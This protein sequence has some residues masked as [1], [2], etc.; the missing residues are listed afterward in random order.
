M[1]RYAGGAWSSLRISHIDSNPKPGQVEITGTKGTYVFD[2]HTYELITHRS[3]G[4]T[5]SRKGANPPSQHGRFYQ[6]IA[7][8][9]RR[10]AKLVITPQWARRPVHVIDLAC[11]SAAAGR[12][13]R[14][15]YR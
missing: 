9:L 11:R 4:S 10:G 5:L 12:A 7:D 2:Y 1:V 13:L 15:K 8:H 3:D 6:N 14:A